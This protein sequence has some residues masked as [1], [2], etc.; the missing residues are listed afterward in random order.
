MITT[1]RDT[2]K[3][4][5]TT[6]DAKAFLTEM[7]NTYEGIAEVLNPSEQRILVLAW[8]D[9]AIVPQGR[10]RFDRVSPSSIG[11]AASAVGTNITLASAA[12]WT[13]TIGTVRAYDSTGELG[14]A[15]YTRSGVNITTSATLCTAV[16]TA[17]TAGRTVRL[18]DTQT[19]LSVG[20]AT[21]DVQILKGQAQFGGGFLAVAN[22]ASALRCLPLHPVKWRVQCVVELTDTT[23]TNGSG[24]GFGAYWNASK[25]YGGVRARVSG[26]YKFACFSGPPTAIVLG[27]A[28]ET[29][30][31]NTEW[32]VERTYIQPF[33]EYTA[34]TESAP[35]GV[36]SKGASAANM[37]LN[38]TP[39]CALLV[40][41]QGT[42]EDLQIAVSRVGCV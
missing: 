12:A 15:E 7:G 41:R 19:E 25:S 11:N 6:D 33:G 36:A 34:L 26:A 3:I 35:S 40:A 20:D 1:H 8:D 30:V 21:R 18:W 10:I 4:F 22:G 2:R 31:G 14:D 17:I 42:T 5:P 9:G 29:P 37:T 24:L 32:I 38:T 39:V 13:H 28:N 23:P 27:S 16:A